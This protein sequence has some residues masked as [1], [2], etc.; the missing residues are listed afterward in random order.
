MWYKKLGASEWPPGFLVKGL[1][2]VTS[3]EYNCLGLYK[4]FL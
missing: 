2:I 3:L 1:T 4:E